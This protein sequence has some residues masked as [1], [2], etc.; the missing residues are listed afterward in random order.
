[1]VVVEECTFDRC[2]ASHW[3]N[4]FDM[5]QKYADVVE[6]QEVVAYLGSVDDDLFTDRMPALVAQD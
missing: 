1:M 6:L 2:E 5:H 3:I 4:L